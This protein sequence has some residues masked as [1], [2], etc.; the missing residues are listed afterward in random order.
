[1]KNCYGYRL[2]WS[3]NAIINNTKYAEK[4]LSGYVFSHPLRISYRQTF[5]TAMN[6]QVLFSDVGFLNRPE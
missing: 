2:V 4:H 1:M 5:S 6:T 3:I